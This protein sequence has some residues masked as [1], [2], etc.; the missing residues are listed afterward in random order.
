MKI[1][2]IA[3]HTGRNADPAT[4]AVTP[5]IHLTTTFEREP[6][7]GYPKG[8]NYSRSGNPNRESLE[9]CLAKLEGGSDAAAFSS[10]SAATMSVLQSLSPGDHVIACD[11]LYHGTRHLIKHFEKWGITSSF[12]DMV[13]IKNLKAEIRKETKVIWV[14]TPSNPLLK[15]IDLQKVSEAAHTVNAIVVCDN[16]W[17]TPILQSPFDFGVDIVMHATTKYIGGHSDILGGAIITKDNNEFFQ[18]IREI[19][20]S[21]GAVPS[22]FEC[23]LTLRGIQTLPLRIRFQSESAMHIAE[24]L[25]SHPNVAAVYYPGLATHPGHP[26]ASMQMK[27]YGGMISFEVKGGK[28]DAM[29]VAA[30]VKLFTRATSLGGPESLIEH[31]ASVEGPDTKTPQT[32]LRLSIGLEHYEDL[33]EDLENALKIHY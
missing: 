23:W 24:F 8:F 11:D 9:Q 2:T 26:V 7:G 14:E 15:I 1:E 13:N 29:K 27:L 17:A 33:I 19:Q 30:K 5:P 3:V 25:K 31:R 20:K 22:P 12:V 18:K 28:E 21:G 6:D 32:L 10:G 16:T 4:G